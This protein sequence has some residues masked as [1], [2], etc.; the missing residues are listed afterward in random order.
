MEGYECQFCLAPGPFSVTFDCKDPQKV[1]S[2]EW[3]CISHPAI[4]VCAWCAHYLNVF[5][6]RRIHIRRITTPTEC[7]DK[8][9][10]VA[11]VESVE[12]LLRGGE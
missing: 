2:Q 8:G 5:T 3:T 6:D 7:R 11:A 10:M 1:G 9:A 12:R 4:A